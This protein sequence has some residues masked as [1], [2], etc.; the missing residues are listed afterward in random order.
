[1]HAALVFLDRYF[2]LRTRLRVK[3]EPD[4]CVTFCLVDTIEPF[5]QVFARERSVSLLEA[6]E[7]PVG[8]ALLAVDISLCIGSALV[9]K[10]AIWPG[11]PLRPLAYVNETLAI[12]VAILI[13]LLRSECNLEHGFG[14]DQL[15]RRLGTGRQDTFGTDVEL[16]TQVLAV[17]V[18]AQLMSAL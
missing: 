16:S 14:D 9:G 17:A 8:L 12:V 1:M 4:L 18:F 6:A 5:D 11:A 3:L 2:A 15:A 10:R 13:H 7:A